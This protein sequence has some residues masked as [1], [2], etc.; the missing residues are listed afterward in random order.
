MILFREEMIEQSNA[1]L[2]ARLRSGEDQFVER[3][4][5]KDQDG[6]LRTAVAFAN[7]APIGWPAIL[8]VGV[9]DKGVVEP[10]A[11]N[12]EELQKKITSQIS[13]AYPP[14]FTFPM[15]VTDDQG[16]QCLA[17][18]I[19]GSENRPHFSGKSYVRVGPESIESS[20]AQ[21]TQL[22]AQRTSK[23]G[24]IL[25]W[26]GKTITF[27]Q[28]VGSGFS[29]VRTNAAEQV[30]LECTPFYVTLGSAGGSSRVTYSLSQIEI[31]FDTAR[32]QLKLEYRY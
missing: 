3:K 24:E 14:I 15:R 6:W 17:V 4:T 2:L 22:I 11:P 25:K 29:S 30:V 32:S 19:P 23:A 12:L 28:I 13:R 18:L 10:G 16:F 9:T 27:E 5:F 1:D 7:S 21:F 8:F 20:E 26:K 31:I